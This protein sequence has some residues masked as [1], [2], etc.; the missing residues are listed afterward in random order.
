MR[1]V[2]SREHSR[3]CEELAEKYDKA[4]I[5]DALA[6]ISGFAIAVNTIGNDAEC[7]QCEPEAVNVEECILNYIKMLEGVRIRLREMH[8][9]TDRG[10]H[11]HQT[12]ELIKMYEEYE[13][14]IA[15]DFMGIVHVR[16]IKVGSVVP[17]LPE[18]TEFAKL[19]DEIIQ[20]TLSVLA[21]I[22]GLGEYVGIESILKK[23]IHTTY[24][25]TYLE[26]L[27]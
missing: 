18:A 19:L 22:D 27:Q 16:C 8:W 9:E 20:K 13:D 10:E 11:H 6:K 17:I 12:S 5:A 1:R 4:D 21:A 24:K 26:P 2:M 25:A 3:I 23:I 14:E 7:E 15:E